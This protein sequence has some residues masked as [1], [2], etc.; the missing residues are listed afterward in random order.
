MS[1]RRRHALRRKSAT[2]KR[3]CDFSANAFTL[4]SHGFVVQRYPFILSVLFVLSVLSVLF[5][6][7]I[8]HCAQIVSERPD[9]ALQKIARTLCD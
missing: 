3:A 8:R 5:R 1:W 9:I 4:I 2:Q 7:G 6:T